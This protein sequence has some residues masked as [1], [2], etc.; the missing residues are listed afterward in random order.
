MSNQAIC[1]GKNLEEYSN[2]MVTYR[3]IYVET[4]M[5]QN[6]VFILYLEEDG[7]DSQNLTLFTRIYLHTIKPMI[8]KVMTASLLCMQ[9][10]KTAS[11]LV[12]ITALVYYLEFSE[13]YTL[14]KHT[15]IPSA[16]INPYFT[17]EET[18]AKRG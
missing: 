15:S 14:K 8:E 18:E 10:W 6:S 2:F 9:A 5:F 1:L 11:T 13:L 12:T 17:D 16:I 7:F 4:R 3:V